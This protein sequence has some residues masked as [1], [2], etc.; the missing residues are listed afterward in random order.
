MNIDSLI[1][2]VLRREGGFVDHPADRG[3]ATNYG[4]TR[5]TLAH[6]RGTTS[7][8]AEDVETMT[9]DEA[10]AIYRARYF[11]EPKIDTL[12]LRIQPQLFDMAVNHGPKKAVR[13]LQETL[14]AE[15]YGPLNT[16]GILGP[17][18]RLL[19]ENAERSLDGR[20]NNAL[21]N[22]RI[23]FYRNIVAANPSQR[24]FLKGWLRRAEEFRERTS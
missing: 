8:S 5:T 15:G 12:P 11:I 24:V 14:N 18:T 21:V 23:C 16:D 10:R 7:V 2:D 17:V 20:L 1:D 13:M 6:W 9:R 22:T 3:G 4:I 19:A